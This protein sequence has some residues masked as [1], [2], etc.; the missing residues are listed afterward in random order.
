[1]QPSEERGC[2][3]LRQ[4]ALPPICLLPLRD[5][6]HFWLLTH[7]IFIVVF[8]L[9]EINDLDIK[10]IADHDILWLQVSMSCVLTLQI[11]QHED[12][13]GW[14][15]LD[16]ALWEPGGLFLYQILKGAIWNILHYYIQVF[17]IG[18]RVV[19]FRQKR[20]CFVVAKEVLLAKDAPRFVG[21][22][23]EVPI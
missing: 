21:L 12:Y 17:F 13:L 23:K 11:L 22:A 1:M 19:E 8:S 5:L 6:W 14:E 10:V 4:Y 15:E 18:K 2:V 3:G 9:P 7:N 20:A 16:G